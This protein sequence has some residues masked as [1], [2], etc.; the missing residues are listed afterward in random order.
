MTNTVTT[1]VQLDDLGNETVSRAGKLGWG[2]SSALLGQSQF[3]FDTQ[4]Q[5]E[6]AYWAQ[7]AG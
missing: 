6:E 5:A 4:A 1:T 2:W 7:I 3:G